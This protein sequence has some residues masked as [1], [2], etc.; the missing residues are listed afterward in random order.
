MADL[1]KKLKIQTGVVKRLSKDKKS[2][3]QEAKSIEK[4]IEDM[5][6]QGKDEY[7]IKKRYECLEETNMM[8]PDCQKRLQQAILVLENLL[9]NEKDLGETEEYKAAQSELT[10]A[11]QVS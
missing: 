5:K 9:E 11:K 6:A 2:Y 4:K 10:L 8:I 3:E 7:D 1:Q